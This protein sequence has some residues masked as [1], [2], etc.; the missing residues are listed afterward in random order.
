[1]HSQLWEMGAELEKI[2]ILKKLKNKIF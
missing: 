1:M 2:M